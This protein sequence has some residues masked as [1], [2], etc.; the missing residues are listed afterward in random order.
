MNIPEFSEIE[1]KLIE[2]KIYNSNFEKNKLIE[3]YQLKIAEL[4]NKLKQAEE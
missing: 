4:E 3:N 2:N 1:N